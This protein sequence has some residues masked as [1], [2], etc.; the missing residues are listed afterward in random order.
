MKPKFD[1]EYSRCISIPNADL[2]EVEYNH[3][4]DTD[5]E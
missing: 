3:E 2:N 1:R 5:C 4:E